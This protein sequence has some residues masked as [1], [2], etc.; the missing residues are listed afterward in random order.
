MIDHVTISIG[1]VRT[2]CQ[3]YNDAGLFAN[4]PFDTVD[5]LIDRSVN[6]IHGISSR[7]TPVLIGRENQAIAFES[8]T[9]YFQA[10]CFPTLRYNDVFFSL[11]LWIN[12]SIVIGGGSLVHVST[13]QNG[14]GAICYDLLGFTTSGVL[15]AQWMTGAT[16]LANLTGRVLPLNTWSHI[17]LIYSLKNGVRL[18]LNGQLFTAIVALPF[19]TISNN[20]ITLGNN[21][22]GLVIPSSTCLSS[23]IVAGPYRGAIDEFRIYM[24]ELNMD[25]LCVL[26]NI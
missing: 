5:T 3:I 24:R 19:N 20:Y 26:A 1:T 8:N 12:P 25:E 7:L 14:T 4:Y 10:L 2:A 13:L 23:L 22:P 6:M 16:S 15:M 9:S 21:S 17:A 11:V 18:Y